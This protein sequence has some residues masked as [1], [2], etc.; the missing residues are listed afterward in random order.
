MSSTDEPAAKRKRTKLNDEST[1][2]TDFNE[3]SSTTTLT[4]A[5]TSTT[6]ASGTVAELTRKIDLDEWDGYL[7]P[8]IKLLKEKPGSYG[9]FEVGLCFHWLIIIWI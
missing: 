8:L 6:M 5:E 9:G 2:E 1:V 7:Y 4:A 3:Q